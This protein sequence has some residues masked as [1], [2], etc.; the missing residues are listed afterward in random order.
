MRII[1]LVPSATET[2]YKIGGGDDL[3][4]V[5][6]ACNQPP[7]A[8]SKDIVV[9][10]RLDTSQ[11]PEDVIDRLVREY[12]ARGESLYRIDWDLIRSL[13]PDLIVVQGLCDVCAVAPRDLGGG[14]AGTARILE[15]GPGSVD[16]ILSDIIRLGEAIGR[17]SEASELVAAIRERI[18]RIR[19]RTAFL[20]SR[21]VFLMEWVNP[22]FCSGHWVPEL[23]AI[24]GG[25]DLGEKGRHS[26]R[27]TSA[28]II[29]HNP[30]IVIAA[31][32]GFSLERASMDALNLWDMD[33]VSSINALVDGRL[34]A[35]DAG[36]YFSRHGPSIAEATE[37]L[38]EIIHPSL[39]RGLA[40]DGS[41]RRIG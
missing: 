16:E 20:E 18:G 3:V 7:E 5:T 30:D 39:F 32:C 34:Y 9:T 40:P 8:L 22:P 33:W 15:V 17:V 31:P 25:R 21:S 13:K 14:L 24:A 10:P 26:R 41:Y 28:E 23:V 19:E 37:I 4:G 6:Y 11:L 29:S 2:I 1:S 12:A 35:V 38:A 27:V 36:R